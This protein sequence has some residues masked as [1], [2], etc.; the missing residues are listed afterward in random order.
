MTLL[1]QTLAIWGLAIGMQSQ[2]PGQSSNS[3]TYDETRDWIVSK[4]VDAGGTTHFPAA[5]DYLTTIH[6]EAVSMDNCQLKYT[7]AGINEYTLKQ[8]KQLVWKAEVRIELSKSNAV[9]QELPLQFT[10]GKGHSY[11]KSL[12]AFAT[13]RQGVHVRGPIDEDEPEPVWRNESITNG[14]L[15]FAGFDSLFLD[16]PGIDSNEITPRMMRA[17]NHAIGICQQRQPQAKEPF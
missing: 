14:D 7:V 12:I 11:S 1:F 16:Q 13:A 9:I 8:Q 15:M 17:L 5:S 6:Y 4:I 2:S 10:D 3:P